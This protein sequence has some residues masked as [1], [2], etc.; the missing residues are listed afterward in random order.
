MTKK[1]DKKYRPRNAADPNSLFN[2]INLAKPISEEKRNL[3]EIGI[4]TALDAF[5]KGQAIKYHFDTLASTVDL[6][7]MMANTLFNGDYANEIHPARYAMIR[8]R[9]RYIRTGKLGSRR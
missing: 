1:R 7:M 6:T 4:R 5:T 8:C 2:A 3:L 9:E